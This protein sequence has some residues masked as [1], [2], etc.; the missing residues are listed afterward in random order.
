MKVVE[1]KA[2]HEGGR[3]S[4]EVGDWPP[5]I[6]EELKQRVRERKEAQ[7]AKM[8]GALT[9][10]VARKITHDRTLQREMEGTSMKAADVCWAWVAEKE[11]MG[12]A[13]D[14]CAR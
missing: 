11:S 14:W 9:Q 13:K 1:S 10:E 7:L 4:V 5:P 3:S 2:G 12:Q 6:S 8:G